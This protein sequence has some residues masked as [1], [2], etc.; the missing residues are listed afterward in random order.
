MPVVRLIRPTVRPT[1]PLRDRWRAL[2]LRLSAQALVLLWN[3]AQSA[4]PVVSWSPDHDT[5]TTERS[6][7]DARRPAVGE[8][9]AVGRLATT[10]RETGYNAGR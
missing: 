9:G 1:Q 8:S 2:G 4:Q 6:P 10:R 5:A 3:V 7:G